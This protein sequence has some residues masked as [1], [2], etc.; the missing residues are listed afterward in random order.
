MHLSFYKYYFRE[1]V[2]TLVVAL[3][4]ME[5]IESPKANVHPVLLREAGD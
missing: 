2:D 4:E 3:R 1:F 5:Q